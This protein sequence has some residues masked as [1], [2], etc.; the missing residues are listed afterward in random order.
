[1]YIIV[2]PQLIQIDWSLIQRISFD[3]GV[4]FSKSNNL[5][6]FDDFFCSPND[7]IC[8][9]VTLNIYNNNKYICC[10]ITFK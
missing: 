8:Y 5:S 7:I 4:I 3:D 9:V 10:N 6:N 2:C 1:M